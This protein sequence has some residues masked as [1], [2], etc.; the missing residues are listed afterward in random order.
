MSL[1]NTIFAAAIALAVP[2]AASAATISGT[3]SASQGPSNFVDIDGE[4]VEQKTYTG[5]I[6]VPGASQ[7]NIVFD[8]SDVDKA[9][10][11]TFNVINTSENKVNFKIRS[12]VNQ[13]D[14]DYGFMGG[15]DLW[16]SGELTSIAGGDLFGGTTLLE[17]S[18]AGND[19][20]FFTYDFGKVYGEEGNYPDI[21]FRVSATVVPIPAAGFLLIGALGGLAAVRRRKS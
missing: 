8:A 14:T 3:I 19:T 4:I 18:L 6:Y 5:D 7:F 17:G 20:T 10:L 9:G 16:L 1:R 21:D 11:L 12:T 2:F 15:V 13:G